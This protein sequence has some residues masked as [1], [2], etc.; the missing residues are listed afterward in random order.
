MRGGAV[1]GH[2]AAPLS[3]PVIREPSEVVIV[4]VMVRSPWAQEPLVGYR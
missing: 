4:Q 3:E 1:G 2:L